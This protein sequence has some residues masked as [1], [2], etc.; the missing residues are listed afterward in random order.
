MLKRTLLGWAIALL[1]A[2]GLPVWAQNFPARTVR[3]VVPYPAGGPADVVAR[4]LTPRLATQLRQPVI[5]DNKAGAAG[6]IGVDAV[7]KAA[8]D[9]YTL[10]FAV[11]SALTINPHI[12]KA[13]PFDPLT[14]FT[15]ISTVLDYMFILVVNPQVP[16]NTVAEL[17]GYA[18]KNP[19]KVAF[20]SAGVGSGNHLAGELL[21]SATGAPMLHVPYKGSAPA[22]TAVISGE[23]SFM[24]DTTGTAINYIRS[25]K[26][27]ALAVTSVARN[28][29]LPDLPTMIEAGTPGFEVVG[30]YGFIGPVRLPEPVTS[31]FIQ[32]LKVV[33][34][35]PAVEEQL[36][37]QGFDIKLTMSE[38]FAKRIKTEYSLWNKV[39][40]QANIEKN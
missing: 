5:V 16:V 22:M 15:P 30:W 26:V 27:R 28:K 35:D 14:D 33:M 6:A 1:A 29:M 17:V 24:F 23:V 31:R 8:P 4:I 40:R 36:R 38:D 13:L 2:A 20:S 18:K 3:V 19:G 21:K 32:A 34:S 9:G 10:L 39:V 12:S 11:N 37:V 7:A 25:G